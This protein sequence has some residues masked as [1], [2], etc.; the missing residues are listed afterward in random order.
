[1]CKNFDE[2]FKS[3][4]DELDSIS[5]LNLPKKEKLMLIHYLWNYTTP[6]TYISQLII[7]EDKQ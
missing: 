7:N 3:I 6:Y 1:M 2:I 4:N 5:K